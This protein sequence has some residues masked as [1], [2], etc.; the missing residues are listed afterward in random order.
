MYPNRMGSPP[1]PWWSD[2]HLAHL[3]EASSNE[4]PSSMMPL[5]IRRSHQIL[6][7]L[8]YRL[9]LF[10]EGARGGSKSPFNISQQVL[11]LLNDS[12]LPPLSG[13]F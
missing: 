10:G 3:L 4:I 6:G 5:C 1:L 11:I 7:R 13:C 9:G 2:A 12:S 8:G